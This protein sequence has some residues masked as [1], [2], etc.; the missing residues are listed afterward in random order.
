MTI[1]TPR[2]GIMAIAPYVG[3]D[4]SLDDGGVPVKMSANESPLGPSPGA[5][6]AFTRAS[7]ELHRYPDGGADALRAAIGERHGL[8]SERIVCGAGSDELINLLIGAY[9]GP[10]DEVLYSRHGFLM[11]KINAMS[12]GASPV[13]AREENYT[14]SVDALLDAVTERTK[15]VFLANPN[16]PTGTYLPADE[17]AR[18]QAGLPDAVLLVIDAAYA[19][20]VS[21]NDYSAGAELVQSADNVVMLRTFSKIYGL[22]ALRLGWAYCPEHVVQVLQR[23]RSPFNVNSAA[24]AAGVAAVRDIAHTD[25]ARTHNDIWLP[26]LTAEFNALGLEVIPSVGNFVSARV[27]TGEGCQAALAFLNRRAILP[28]AIQAYGLPDHLRFSVG[29]EEENLRVIEALNE[30]VAKRHG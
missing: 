24:Q 25:K 11:Y 13:A 6:A 29:L 14:A 20:Y 10:G 12:A 23:V 28:R 9:A 16:N 1:P 19:E 3:G 18:L 27:G 8:A 17:L 5:I 30:F 15:M 4:A 7:G 22:A 26:R 2:D 21:R